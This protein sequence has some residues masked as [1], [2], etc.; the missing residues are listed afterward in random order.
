MDGYVLLGIIIA[1]IAGG[2][3]GVQRYRDRRLDSNLSQALD[4]IRQSL[5]K[6]T[7][8]PTPEYV[9]SLI[10]NVIERKKDEANQAEFEAL[11]DMAIQSYAKARE[12]DKLLHGL[13]EEKATWAVQLQDKELELGRIKREAFHNIERANAQ[14]DIEIERINKDYQKE[15]V[16]LKNSHLQQLDALK[17]E[18]EKE[19]TR[20][21][22]KISQ[23]YKDMEAL[24]T[25][26]E[27][28]SGTEDSG[29]VDVE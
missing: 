12:L 7:R 23:Q 8:G 9:E 6:G 24:K 1:V 4:G 22:R 29:P 16:L 20:M 25:T 21:S 26:I 19:T 11:Q 15:I 2:F 27:K 5:E 10:S 13:V 18:H 14:R 28:L 3:F 17:R